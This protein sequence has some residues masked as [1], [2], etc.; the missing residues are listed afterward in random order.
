MS[1]ESDFLPVALKTFKVLVCDSTTPW[2]QVL[3]LNEIQTLLNKLKEDRLKSVRESMEE[4]CTTIEQHITDVEFTKVWQLIAIAD[5]AEPENPRLK[6]IK[7]RLFELAYEQ[8]HSGMILFQKWDF[9]SIF[10]FERALLIFPFF[11]GVKETKEK[12][13]ATLRAKRAADSLVRNARA[14]CLSETKKALVLINEALALFPDHPEALDLIK[15][16]DLDPLLKALKLSCELAGGKAALTQGNYRQA[17]HVF[18][19]LVCKEYSL[20]ETLPLFQEA[21]IQWQKQVRKEHKADRH[22]VAQCP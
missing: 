20:N 6:G 9:K 22:E 21:A 18:H 16:Y 11:E 10:L 13:E 3:E 1:T 17:A 8:F 4:M 5:E 19:S 7:L 15:E 2:E 14:L 12:A